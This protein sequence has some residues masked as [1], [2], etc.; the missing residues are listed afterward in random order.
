MVASQTTPAA[1]QETHKWPISPK[2]HTLFNVVHDAQVVRFAARRMAS[3]HV[4][5]WRA[6]MHVKAREL[7]HELYIVGGPPGKIG[8]VPSKGSGR[9]EQTNV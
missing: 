7:R 6:T 1:Q 8:R 3:R 5:E 2:S 9:P 4:C